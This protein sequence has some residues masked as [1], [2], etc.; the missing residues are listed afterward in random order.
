MKEI[1]SFTPTAQQI[2]AAENLFVFMTNEATVRPV[3]D[4]YQARILAEHQFHIDPQWLIPRGDSG[5]SM[6][7][8]VI[9]DP[10]DSFL[11]GEEDAKVFFAECNEARIKAKLWVSNPAFCP[12]LVS[13]NN[14]IDA[15][16][17][18]LNAMA[19]TPGLEFLSR[20]YALDMEKHKEVVGLSLK[21][22]APFVANADVLLER[23]M[24]D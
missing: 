13:E 10:K 19:T 20:A 14:R 3:V 23:I 6:D 12:L 9:L 2:R 1:P 24:A 11:L 7:D 22:L 4:A 17:A 15:E 21:L 5:R 16:N 18:L 8:R